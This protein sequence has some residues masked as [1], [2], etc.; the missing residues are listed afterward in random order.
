MWR[1][2]EILQR[3]RA[4]TRANGHTLTAREWQTLKLE[5]T[6]PVIRQRFGS[7]PE[8]LKA[9]G[10]SPASRG[11]AE[12]REVQQRFIAAA[13][14]YSEAVDRRKWT[15]RHPDLPAK[16][17]V[18]IFGSWTNAWRAAGVPVERT[19]QQ[20]MLRELR[21]TYSEMGRTLNE[22]EWDRAQKRPSAAVV[23]ARLGSFRVAWLKAGVGAGVPSIE[24]D[25]RL[26]FEREGRI[27][28][29]A[30]WD[31]AGFEPS[32]AIV[33]ETYG[34][35]RRAWAAVGLGNKAQQMALSVERLQTALGNDEAALL[36]WLPER[37]ASI[38]RAFI[39]AQKVGAV[40]RQLGI[41]HQ[42]VYYVLTMAERRLRE[43]AN[44][45]TKS[46]DEIRETFLT[47]A[48]EVKSVPSMYEWTMA[49]LE[50]PAGVVVHAFGSWREA[51]S[52]VERS[53]VPDAEKVQAE[54][55]RLFEKIGGRPTR[56]EWQKATGLSSAAIRY[57]FG[58][59]FTAWLTVCGGLTAPLP[60]ALRKDMQDVLA[61]VGHRPSMTEWDHLD[62]K[63]AAHEIVRTYGPWGKVWEVACGI[64]YAGLRKAYRSVPREVVD[65]ALRQALQ[66]FGF[67]PS[68]AEWT[69]D[70]LEP[71]VQSVLYHYGTWRRAWRE[72]CGAEFR[73]MRRREVER[74]T[75]AKA[76]AVV[77]ERLGYRPTMRQWNAAGLQPH[78]EEIAATFHGWNQAWHEVCGVEINRE[79]TKQRGRSAVSP[80]QAI[81]AMRRVLQTLHR[82]P[83]RREWDAKHRRP[84]AAE[85][86]ALFGSWSQAWNEVAPKIEGQ[87]IE[88]RPRTSRRFN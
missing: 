43:M 87:E 58:D 48:K 60:T 64:P 46:K 42:S 4:E 72:V 45:V 37:Q 8:A 82:I 59:W 81:T 21:R 61:Q 67:T 32:A 76:M 40:A 62:R 14:A 50:P 44:W 85:I 34:G 13:R 83:S 54:M 6:L 71:P 52:E 7:W 36:Q 20:A 73:R 27:L 16:R 15:L 51:W 75:A 18:S 69:R 31:A 39:D 55:R 2:A 26:A 5:P 22:S 49:R 63:I 29:R 53:S 47:Q 17:V 65:A 77:Y 10:L 80:Q 3:L 68:M 25:L 35:W 24:R 57:H 86:I 12:R 41:S 28:T 19:T 79:Q 70:D 9:A 23:A 84:S 74:D 66:S 30:E 88:Q 11:A 38:V 78:A 56:A 33:T 1:K